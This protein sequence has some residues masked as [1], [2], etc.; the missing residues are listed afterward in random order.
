MARFD[1]QGLVVALALGCACGRPAEQDRHALRAASFGPSDRGALVARVGGAEVVALGES[2]HLTA[3]L[4]GPRLEILRTLHE[5]L[6]FDVVAFEGSP[7]DH[8]IAIDEAL[9]SEQPETQASAA[10]HTAW[11]G[12]WQTEAM[13]EVLAYALSTLRGPR[14]LYPTSF[15][16][17]PGLGR[18]FVSGERELLS[19][20]VDRVVRYLPAPPE[21]EAAT[22]VLRAAIGPPPAPDPVAVETAILALERWLS[23]ADPIVERR[24]G[25][26]HGRALL[27]VAESIRAYLEIRGP[28]DRAYH[29]RRDAS[30]AMRAL[31]IVH[32]ISARE[33]LAI[34]GHHS[35]VARTAPMGRILDRAIGD[36]YRIVGAFAGG[37][38][39]YDFDDDRLLP[40]L[41]RRLPSAPPFEAFLGEVGRS[42]IVVDLRAARLAGPTTSRAE[43]RTMPLAPEDFDLAIYVDRVRAPALPF[44]P[45]SMRRAADLVGPLLDAAPLLPIPLLIIAMSWAW[46][47]RAAGLRRARNQA[48]ERADQGAKP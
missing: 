17:Q 46:R 29:E 47:R 37:G 12:L 13:R 40:I 41:R 33:R 6:D 48:T 27:L 30:N 36:R 42:P 28:V 16:L 23:A 31:R 22:G 14:P 19:A 7:I 20:F 18:A 34:W 45:P 5:A 21:L 15:D 44:V 11:F 9:A 1:R 26:A 39:F 38:T 32:E 24:H 8:W 3:E 4:P 25:R 2:I 10:Q 43:G 35:H